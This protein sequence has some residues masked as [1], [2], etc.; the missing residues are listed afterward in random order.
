MVTK[1]HRH[2]TIKN[3]IILQENAFQIIRILNRQL[4]SINLKYVK[5][6]VKYQYK[7]QLR[8]QLDAANIP[9]L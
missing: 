1:I 2:I 5:F 9:M 3:T 7:Q 6:L 4:V 8:H